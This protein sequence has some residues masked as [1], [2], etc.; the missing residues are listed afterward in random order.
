MSTLPPHT[1]HPVPSG[2]TH[3][4]AGC[5]QPAPE[6]QLARLALLQWETL[7]P[8]ALGWVME[9]LGSALAYRNAGGD[10]RDALAFW[11]HQ[12][13]GGR[14]GFRARHQRIFSSPPLES[15]ATTA[16]F[17][18]QLAGQ[19]LPGQHWL[20]HWLME[21]NHH[22][23]WSEEDPDYPLALREAEDPALDAPQ[24]V[25]APTAIDTPLFANAPPLAHASPVA[26]PPPLAHAPARPWRVLFVEGSRTLLNRPLLAIVGGRSCSDRG[27]EIAAGFAALLSG[28]GLTIV[29]GLAEGIDGAAHRGALQGAGSTLAVMATGMD[30]NYPGQHAALRQTIAH[31]GAVV[32]RL[33]PGQRVEKFRFLQRNRIIAGLCQAVLVIQARLQ[34]GALSTAQAATDFGR[35]VF[36]VPGSI[37]DPRCKGCHRLIRQGAVLVERVEDIYADMPSLLARHGSLAPP[38]GG[39]PVDGSPG[40][41]RP[42]GAA[43][44]S[45]RQDPLPGSSNPAWS[46]ALARLGHDPFDVYHLA[47]CLAQRYDEALV[48]A[49]RMEVAGAIRRLADGRYERRP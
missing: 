16:R 2:R 33:M 30:R 4:D 35:G 47:T 25:D 17:L 11:L 22:V 29:S 20:W 23:L 9:H 18:A 43:R 48:E 32:T 19:A 28:Q 7:G 41:T 39:Q 24:V 10:A 45:D 21:K 14:L 8:Y 49:L 37:D 44:A 13:I 15:R 38:A 40:S 27:A 3:R 1:G 42:A 5:G 31:K 6:E 34:S 12:E 36:A 46:Q 26:N